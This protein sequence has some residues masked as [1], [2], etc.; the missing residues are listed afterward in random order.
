MIARS[1]GVVGVVVLLVTG[2]LA[3][4]AA[5]QPAAPAAPAVQEPP[6][7]KLVSPAFAD[8]AMLPK[9]FTCSADGGNTVSPPLQWTNPPQGVV[10]YA[11]IVSG[12]DN[13]PQKG[14][15][16]ETFWIRWNIPATAT[17]LTQGQPVGAELPD[18]SRQFKGGRN[19]VGY[20]GPCPP[21][22]VGVHHYLFKIYALDTM[23]TLPP[24]PTRAQVLAAMDGHI[25]RPSAYY[26]VFERP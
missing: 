23:L 24:E 5:Q 20:R 11:L 19:I 16:E 1:I 18:G 4:A 6:K 22:G 25:I 2:G 3:V 8:G 15:L 12:L 17:G 14:A 10:S 13:H 21:P 26:A 9:A 7:L